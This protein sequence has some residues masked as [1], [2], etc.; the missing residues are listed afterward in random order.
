M[1]YHI[2]NEKVVNWKGQK[3]LSSSTRIMLDPKRPSLYY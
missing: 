1:Y 2:S 3:D